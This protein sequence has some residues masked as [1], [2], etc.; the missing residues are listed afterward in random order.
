M[1]KLPAALNK[2]DRG[3]INPCTPEKDRSGTVP[4]VRNGWSQVLDNR[5]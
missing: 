5:R 3:H 1:S 2:R 4:A